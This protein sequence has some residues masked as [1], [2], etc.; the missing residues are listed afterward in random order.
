MSS[1]KA[2]SILETIIAASVLGILIA[3]ATKSLKHAE[4]RE[5]QAQIIHK[6]DL[7]YR[8]LYSRATSPLTLY[9]TASRTS[10]TPGNMALTA[11]FLP[12]QSTSECPDVARTSPGMS[13]HTYAIATDT[14]SEGRPENTTTRISGTIDN[15]VRYTIN[16]DLC[17]PG[18]CDEKAHFTARSW[19]YSECVENSYRTN[20]C[21]AGTNYQ[22][23][24]ANIYLELQYI[25]EPKK[26][27]ERNINRRWDC[28]RQVYSSAAI[29]H[30]TSSRAAL[31]FPRPS[32]ED[33]CNIENFY[34]PIASERILTAIFDEGCNNNAAVAG[35]E[36]DGKPTCRCVP[37][38][39]PKIVNNNLVINDKGPICELNGR[40]GE[41]EIFRGFEVFNDNR[42]SNAANGPGDLRFSTKPICVPF[43]YEEVTCGAAGSRLKDFKFDCNLQ[44]SGAI[45]K[46]GGVCR[47][48]CGNSGAQNTCFKEK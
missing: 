10:T 14:E 21:G 42:V 36:S 11:C 27:R 38:F 32:V 31:V 19:F 9:V 24:I 35:Y 41:N 45:S 5:R 40:C 13:F 7:L 25:P 6:M 34:S 15:P 1:Q 43:D 20:R 3:G 18:E 23:D 2:Y 46:N 8:D 47:M 22:S 16:G 33:A 48:N 28:Q 29:I 44:C 17:A 4:M 39:S 37:P 26:G 12:P 30:G